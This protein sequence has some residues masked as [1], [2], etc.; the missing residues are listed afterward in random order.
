[1]GLERVAVAVSLD[2]EEEGLFGGRYD[3]LRTP[4][5]NLNHLH[6]L[7]PLLEL[8]IRPTLF[9]AWPVFNRGYD[10]ISALAGDLEIGAHLHWW[11]TP[12][13]PANGPE[14][15]HSVPA[16]SMAPEQFAV[17]MENLLEAAASCTGRP[18]RSF[19]MGRWD[20]H[21]AMLP[22]LARLGIHCDASVRPLHWLM[23]NGNGPDHFGAPSDPYYVNTYEGRI[24]EIPLT[25]IPLFRWLGAISP[26]LLPRF[27]HWGA[28]ALLAIYHPLWLLKLT[29]RLHIQRGGK[30]LSLTWH[31]SEMMPG[32][33]P[34]MGTETAVK[35]FLHKMITYFRW[36]K[37][38]YDVEWVHMADLWQRDF[39]AF[40][41]SSQNTEGAA[42]PAYPGGTD[43]L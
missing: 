21:K 15:L 11:N 7:Q 6:R 36:L 3:C 22:V 16:R 13:L 37:A 18:V 38:N 8:G 12:P 33:A 27:T 29:T 24:L 26:R 19:R 17:K 40:V 39:P 30:V 9:C 28:M 41:S 31:S 32:G 14:F 43:W 23:D 5:L 4:V 20:L 35:N 2:V 34:H 1:M 42:K 25:V 10:K